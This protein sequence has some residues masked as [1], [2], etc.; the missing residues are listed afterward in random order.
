MADLRFAFGLRS[1]DCF[2]LLN[3]VRLSG[4]EILRFERVVLIIVKF[5]VGCG[6]RCARLFPFD[7]TIAFGADGAA[8]DRA[9]APPIAR[10]N[11]KNRFFIFGRGFFKDRDEALAF[12]GL[13]IARTR[14]TR[15]VA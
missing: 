12:E 14:Q 13:R 6:G 9:V 8:E 5:E 3:N 1:K 11:V 7:E 2:E 10:K 15:E 4:S